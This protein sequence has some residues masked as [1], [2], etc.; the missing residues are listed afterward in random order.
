[1]DSWR[2]Y[3]NARIAEEDTVNSYHRGIRKCLSLCLSVCLDN[4][5]NKKHRTKSSLEGNNKTPLNKTKIGATRRICASWCLCW[6]SN[7]TRSANCRSG[8]GD[9]FAIW[10]NES[11]LWTQLYLNVFNKYMLQSLADSK[12]DTEFALQLYPG[13]AGGNNLGNGSAVWQRQKKS[14]TET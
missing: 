8:A 13:Y 7:L 3:K 12:D 10:N 1:M 5:G 14:R 9:I 2:S 6:Q 11:L 4:R